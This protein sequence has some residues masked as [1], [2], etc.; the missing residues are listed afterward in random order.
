[1]ANILGVR[2]DSAKLSDTQAGTH[3][4]RLAVDPGTEQLEG[5]VAVFEI[6]VSNGR[7]PSAKTSSPVTTSFR[8]NLLTDF[9][10]RLIYLP[11]RSQINLDIVIPV[12]LN[13]PVMLDR[14][15][16][17]QASTSLSATESFAPLHIALT[18]LAIKAWPLPGVSL[19]PVHS[20]SFTASIHEII[21]A[22]ILEAST[23]IFI[24]LLVE[25]IRDA[26]Q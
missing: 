25:L 4:P 11:F 18:W 19:Q 23:P 5:Y 17:S 15:G 2:H 6:E 20:A 16:P 14:P 26:D 24:A 22:E 13:N 10:T 21:S 12:E 8:H 3:E 1:M 9:E 7:L